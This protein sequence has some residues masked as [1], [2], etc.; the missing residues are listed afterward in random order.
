MIDAIIVLVAME[1]VIFHRVDGGAVAINP[2]QVTSLRNPIGKY[3]QLAPTGNCAIDLTDR[4]F[5]M[6]IESC[7]QVRRILEQAR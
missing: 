2:T 7:D 6:V 3:R 1:L 4:K 5:I